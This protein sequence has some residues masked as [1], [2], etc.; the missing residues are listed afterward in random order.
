MSA[1]YTTALVGVAALSAGADRADRERDRARLARRSRGRGRCRPCSR[2]SFGSPSCA[3]MPPQPVASAAA[4]AHARLTRDPITWHLT[5]FFAVQ[6][7]GFYTLARVDAEHLREPRHRQHST[8]AAARPQRD[9]GDTGGAAD[10][11]VAARAA[12]P[13]DR[14]RLADGGRDAL[15]YGGLLLAPASGAGAVG[16][17]DRLRPGSMLPARADDD[18]PAQRLAAGRPR[19]LSTHVQAIGTCW[20]PA[21]R[22]G[23]ARRDR[24]WTLRSSCLWRRSCRR[25]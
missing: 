6:S 16:G 22:R 17:P 4:G 25:R 21:A 14:S 8:R 18:R 7:C 3:V 1:L 12:R 19:A 10:S 23:A 24:S 15:G 2:R 11:A 9:H 20:P 13:A 5:V